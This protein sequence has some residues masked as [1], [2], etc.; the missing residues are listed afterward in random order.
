MVD[1]IGLYYVNFFWLR[2]EKQV[3]VEVVR[4]LKAKSKVWL[5]LLQAK[6]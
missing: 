3:P 1:V 4:D 5:I 2:N 6:A